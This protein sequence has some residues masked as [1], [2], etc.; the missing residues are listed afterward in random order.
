MA[1][2]PVL[3]M[4]ACFCYL[5]P[6]KTR[7]GRADHQS[8]ISVNYRVLWHHETSQVSLLPVSPLKPT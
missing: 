4:S 7:Q 5:S 2:C 3:Q 8:H 1:V 6:L